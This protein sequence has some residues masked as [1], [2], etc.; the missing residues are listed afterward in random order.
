[1]ITD[2]FKLHTVFLKDEIQLNVKDGALVTTMRTIEK[3]M[4]ACK[5]SKVVFYSPAFKTYNNPGIPQA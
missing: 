1:M 2:C 5:Q 3:I 4:G